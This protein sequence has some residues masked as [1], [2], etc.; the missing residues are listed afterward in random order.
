MSFFTKFTYLLN[1]QRDSSKV[2]LSICLM[3]LWALSFT[4]AMSFVKIVHGEIHSLMILFLRCFF[5]FLFF[6][7]FVVKGGISNLRTKRPFLHGIR[8]ILT[9]TGMFC[10]Y[11]AYR[12]L[13]LAT[14]SA[15]GFTSPLFTT[16][17]SFLFFKEHISYKKWM[18]IFAGYLG[19]LIILRP[20]SLHLDNAMYVALLANAVASGAIIVAKRLS[21]T[22]STVTI[23][24]YTNIATFLLSSF[25][26]LWVW[27]TP[28]IREILILACVGLA[29]ILSQF[30]YIKALQLGKPSFLAPFEYTRLLFAIVVGT[31]FFQESLDQWSLMGAFV[32][33]FATFF[34]S[35]MEMHPEK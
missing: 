1:P 35:R 21:S 33:I 2:A 16:I 15:I 23:L 13:P 17:F 6:S 12:H 11:Y 25:A 22:E 5:G 27:Q 10:T 19:V 8:V 9:C 31:L 18:V 4:T 28:D 26:V 29:G 24:F 30:F 20:F 3:I 14:A 34:L 32:I 7:P